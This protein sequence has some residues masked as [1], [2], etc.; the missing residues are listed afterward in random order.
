MQEINVKQLAMALVLLMLSITARADAS[1]DLAAP[2]VSG[3]WYAEDVQLMIKPDAKME[4]MIIVLKDAKLE[5]ELDTADWV[6]RKVTVKMPLQAGG[7]SSWTIGYQYDRKTFL[8]LDSPEMGRLVF[9]F[10]RN[11]TKTDLQYI[12][13]LEWQ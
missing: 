12:D 5:A 9:G 11:L 10:S 4:T 1:F 6:N 13:K 8:T 7:F 2:W 3:V